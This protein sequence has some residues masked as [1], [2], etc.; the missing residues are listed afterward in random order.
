MLTVLVLTRSVLFPTRM[1]ALSAT[2]LVLHRYCRISSASDSDSEETTEKTST[3]ASGAYVDRAF[4]ACR[5]RE[6]SLA[7]LIFF[8]YLAVRD[9]PEDLHEERR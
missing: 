7:T 3:S 6:S 9:F 1:M 8:I 5:E 2:E 4:S